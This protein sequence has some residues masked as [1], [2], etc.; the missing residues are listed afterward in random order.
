MKHSVS[1]VSAWWSDIVASQYRSPQIRTWA[2]RCDHAAVQQST[3]RTVPVR[4]I[5][6]RSVQEAPVVVNLDTNFQS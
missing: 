6:R 3:P 5:E 4:Y 2:G 1:C